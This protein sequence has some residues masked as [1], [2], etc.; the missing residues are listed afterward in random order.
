M[1]DVGKG[2][3]GPLLHVIPRRAGTG[4]VTLCDGTAEGGIRESEW[5]ALARV[6]GWRE[7]VFHRAAKEVKGKGGKV[8]DGLGTGLI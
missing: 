1:I 5:L 7:G 6:G 4:G 8:K 3:V 2:D